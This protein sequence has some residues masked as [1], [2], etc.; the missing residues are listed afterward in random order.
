MIRVKRIIQTNDGP[1]RD[2]GRVIVDKLQERSMQTM[3][4]DMRH[5]KDCSFSNKMTHVKNVHGFRK[6]SGEAIRNEGL[7]ETSKEVSNG[8]EADVVVWI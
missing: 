2:S 1:S 7:N 5:R 4:Q 6:R 8:L 3:D